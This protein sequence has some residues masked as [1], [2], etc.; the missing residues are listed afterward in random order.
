[1]LKNGD[2]A[3]ASKG[4]GTPGRRTRNTRNAGS[5]AARSSATL[6]SSCSS[7]RDRWDRSRSRTTTRQ[8]VPRRAE[9]ASRPRPPRP[10][11]PATAASPPAAGGERCPLRSAHR[12][13]CRRRTRRSEATPS[14]R[15]RRSSSP[16]GLRGGGAQHEQDRHDAGRSAAWHIGTGYAHVA[17]GLSVFAPAIVFL[18]RT[19]GRAATRCGGEGWR[20]GQE[21]DDLRRQVHLP[22]G[23][24]QAPIGIRR[25]CCRRDGGHVGRS[26][27]AG[28]AGSG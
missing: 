20:G 21:K 18:R 12:A 17:P 13:G 25:G 9:P 2:S 23:A 11:D 28:V 1:M 24:A 19:V 22:D 5:F 4:S 14:R 8:P 6:T 7:C 15:G 16:L 26:G 27:V 3:V 10:S